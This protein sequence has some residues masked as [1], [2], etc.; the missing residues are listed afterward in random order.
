MSLADSEKKWE[1]RTERSFENFTNHPKTYLA[2]LVGIV[3]VVIVALSLIGNALGIANIYWQATK[4]KITAAPRV[5]T[6]VYDTNN[7]IAQVKFFHDKCVG[8]K[9]KV[10]IFQNN[11]ARYQNNL[12]AAE[13]QTDPL[14]RQVA[15]DALGPA[16][17]D[18]TAALNGAQSDA[19]EYNSAAAN[20]TINPF[21]TIFSQNNLP[22]RIELPPGEAAAS[23]FLLNCG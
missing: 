8:V 10:N 1:D 5:T 2:K 22:E 16:Q 11:Y 7:I 17:A 6:Q 9:E 14:Q 23:H 21:R 12:R 20:P 4:A 15:L 13:L 3:V 18:V 19:A